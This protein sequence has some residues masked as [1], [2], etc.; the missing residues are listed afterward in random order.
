M[1]HII[2]KDIVEETRKDYLDY[3]MS[4]IVDRALPDLRDGMKPVHRRIIYAAREM[5]LVH[6][7]P[8]KK[9]AR[10]VGDII[11]K[12]HPH[13]D[14]AVYD[15]MVRMAQDFTL[16]YP[17]IDGQGNF[18]SMDGDSP[19]AM[20]Y[21]EARMSAISQYL[22]K[23][24]HE[25]TVDFQPN[26]DDK[27]K[28]PVVLPAVLPF[29]VLNGADGIAV[30]MATRC[31]PHN[32]VE[33]MEAC[34]HILKHGDIDEDT[35]FKYIQNVDFP[36]GGIV[37]GTDGYRKA[38]QSGSGAFTVRARCE[39]ENLGRNTQALVFTE[40][41]YQVNKSKWVEDVSKM[42][43]EG[44]L[45]GIQDVRDESSR[46]G[47]RVVVFVKRDASP[48]RVMHQ[49]YKLTKAQ[50]QYNVNMTVLN[51]GVPMQM[52]LKDILMEFVA[53][54]KETVLRRTRFRLSAAEK[55][56]HILEGLAVVRHDIDTAISIIRSASNTQE[57]HAALLAKV[58]SSAPV[59]AWHMQVY[60]TPMPAD[61]RLSEEQV[62]SILAMQLQRLTS[63]E[64]DDLMVK[65]QAIM[66]DL[67]YLKSIIDDNKVLQKVILQEWKDIVH[68]HGDARRTEISMESS[69][70]SDEDL[71]EK[72]DIVVTFTR[73]GYIKSQNL[74]DYKLQRRGGTGKLAHNMQDEDSIHIGVQCHT[75]DDILI[76]TDLGKVFRKK[77]YDIPAASRTSKGRHIANFLELL[78]SETVSTIVSASSV[79]ELLFLTKNGLAKRCS[80]DEF[81]NPRK[82]GSQSITLNDGDRLVNV[83]GLVQDTGSCIIT[84]R[85]GKILRFPVNSIRL[86]SRTSK[87]ARCIKL[88][89][90]DSIVSAD[91]V[92]DG[93][94]ILTVTE[95][96]FGKLSS[97][98]EFSE[99]N[100]GGA[101]VLCIKASE[102]TGPTVGSF[103]VQDGDEVMFITNSSK[104]IRISTDTIRET[105]RIAQGVKLLKLDEGDTIATVIVVSPESDK[106]DTA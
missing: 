100:R 80:I 56:A 34:S 17:L 60:G 73:G 53:F 45:D 31:P 24:I 106:D 14:N 3:A 5:G 63:A 93:D 91:A 67:A 35:L 8:Y 39:V 64:Q 50:V 70:I 36:T 47:V 26:Y 76:F 62:Q 89:D 83:I 29:M 32:L 4:C 18:G 71:I 61:Y 88:K 55:K 85:S 99:K 57:A 20:R 94:K 69:D 7:S 11:G 40:F 30:G 65:F 104:A 59:A 52:G 16:R 103:R 54:R 98:D 33:V 68:A 21:T 79:S 58:W 25:D 49:L 97:V 78:S 27:E 66:K 81:T 82:S 87:G 77:G 96:G 23:D 42:A 95:L 15:T 28:E 46:E 43:S 101:P 48:E 19:A 22:V 72:R 38:M 51:K 9:S 102:K 13:G 6:N 37:L 75:H 1:V 10:L 74:Q 41:P 92:E 2:K 44:K 12:Y 84:T 90:S 105:G 86:L